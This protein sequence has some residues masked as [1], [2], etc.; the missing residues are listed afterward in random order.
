MTQ[1]PAIRTFWFQRFSR[2]G[3]AA[4]RWWSGFGA[5]ALL[6]ACASHAPQMSATQEAQVYESHARNNYAPPGPP[7]DP[8]GP[9]IVEAANRFDVPERWI[10]EVMRVES[11]GQLYQA[12]GTLVTSPVGAMG[13]MQLMPETYDEMRAQYSL[14]DDAYDPRNNILAGAAYIRQMYDIY[15]SPGFLAAYNAG[16]ARLDDYL[17]RNRGL[18]DET[19]RYV[20]MI[21]PYIEDVFPQSRSPADLLAANQLPIDIPAGPRYV[22]RAPR[23]SYAA[24]ETHRRRSVERLAYDARHRRGR[25]EPEAIEVAELPEPPRFEPPVASY[26]VTSYSSARHGGFHLISSAMA[27]EPFPAGRSSHSGGHGGARRGSHARLAS[28]H[29]CGHGHRRCM[30][31][32]AE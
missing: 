29:G 16:P 14:G 17:T 19:R 15:G 13:L 5:L 11:R 20:A 32:S 8:W 28:A 2:P 6:S 22:R 12:D 30:V 24:V 26:R 7:G 25:A 27:A 18:P 31:L 23:V 9:Y 10:R 4:L 3:V 1:T 21:G